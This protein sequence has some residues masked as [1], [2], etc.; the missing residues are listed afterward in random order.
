MK[1]IIYIVSDIDKVLSFEWISIS[2]PEKCDFSF[3]IIGKQ[4]SQ[5]ARFLQQER[6]CFYEIA[7][8]RYPSMVSKWF[9][10]LRL[11]FKLR[12]EI[13]HTHLWRANLLGL[14]T[15]WVLRVPK[16]IFTRH[17]ATI[18]YDQHPSG[19]KWDKMCNRMATDIIAIS[20]NTEDILISKDKAN[21]AKVHLIHHGINL[22]YFMDVPARQVAVL[23]EKYKILSE[24]HWPVIGV[25]SRYVDWKGI[26]YIIPAFVQLRTHYPKAHLVLANATGEYRSSIKTLL[27][28]LPASTYTEIEFEDDLA[29]LYQLFDVFV[30]VPVNAMV[31]AFGQTYVEAL[32]AGVPSVFTL[33][34]IARDFI[35]NGENAIVVSFANVDEI[36]EAASLL[37]EDPELRTRLI[38]AGRA[39]VKEQFSLDQMIVRLNRLYGL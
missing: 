34:G 35:R 28:Q 14:T 25:I 3:V 2:L 13:V 15:A 24:N 6:I 21:P 9:G 7:D 10:L 29:A 39:S 32:A 19:L 37:L 16:R 26:Q 12:P 33:S 38:T 5:L 8:S 30:H 31:E 23:R 1:K 27:Q 4:N 11:L 36:T 22:N 20:K 17:H 18:H